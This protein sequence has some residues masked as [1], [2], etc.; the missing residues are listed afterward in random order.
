[1]KT[2]SRIGSLFL[3]GISVFVFF[4]SMK[5]GIGKPQS[6][7]PGFISFLASMV[8]FFLCSWD[9]V[10]EV[11]RSRGTQE[12]K[13]AV[14]WKNSLRPIGLLLLLLGFTFIL[15][16]LGS[17]LSIFILTFLM[18]LIYEPKRWLLHLL[19]SALISNLSFLLFCKWLQ[20]QLPKGML[21]IGW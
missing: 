14:L 7:G 21:G 10:S 3:I 5:L 20:V 19:T 4:G 6:P 16:I 12:K 18:L 13:T 8:L 17:I 1:M 15:E 11:V 2:S 9:L